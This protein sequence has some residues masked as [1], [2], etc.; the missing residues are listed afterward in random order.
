M[1]VDEYGGIAGLVTLEDLMEEL[2]GEIS[3]EYD[4]E[5]VDI[6]DLGANTYRVS[7]RYSVDDLADL[8]DIDIEEDDVDTVGGLLTKYV[9][10]LPVLGSRA[11]T[12]DL[13]LVAEKLEGRPKR[14]AWIH[15][16]PTEAWLERTALRAEI[17]Q[18]VTGEIPLP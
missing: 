13:V 16:S 10:R 17:D 4:E 18:A 8:Y 3:D 7:A 5:V 1:V 12:D 6:H 11:Q 9:G 2:V 15:V 14:V